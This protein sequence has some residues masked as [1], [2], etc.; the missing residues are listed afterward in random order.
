MS[1]PDL[2]EIVGGYVR[3]TRQGRETTEPGAHGGGRAPETVQGID[4][5][6]SIG[7][8]TCA[9]NAVPHPDGGDDRRAD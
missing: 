6:H 4:D 5:G 9:V 3:L 8:Q 2:S 1:D 7:A